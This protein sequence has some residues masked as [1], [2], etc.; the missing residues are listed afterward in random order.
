MRNG[1]SIND[2]SVGMFVYLFL[3]TTLTIL[4]PTAVVFGI[5]KFKN[6]VSD[7]SEHPCPCELSKLKGRNK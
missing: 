7:L 6:V 2:G 1:G 5:M 4:I 3:I